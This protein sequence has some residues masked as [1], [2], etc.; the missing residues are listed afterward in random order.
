LKGI[1][2]TINALLANNVAQ[3]GMARTPSEIEPQTFSVKGVTLSHLSYTFSYNGLSLPQD[4]EWRSALID[5]DRILRDARTAREMGAD[6][7][8]VSMHWGNEMSHQLNSQQISVADALTKSG[9]VDLIVGHHAHVVQPIEKVNG[10][11]VMYGMGNVLSN[12]PTDERW[13]ASSQDAGVFTITMRRST[14]GKVSFDTP[15]V[16]PTWVDKQNGWII[17]DISE[18]FANSNNP[19]VNTRELELSL[20]R[21]TRVLG[22]FIVR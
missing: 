22:E 17:R 18:M 8:I 7:V 21:T 12:L 13:P 1:D 2:E 6:A 3:S 9:D 16:H 11:W 19:G 5:T 4:Q 15:V 14:A 10:V 20:E